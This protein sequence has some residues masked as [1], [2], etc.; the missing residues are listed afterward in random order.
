MKF[1]F[2]GP[3]ECKKI[4]YPGALKWIRAFINWGNVHECR[5][6]ITL[7]VFYSFIHLPL[8][9]LVQFPSNLQETFRKQAHGPIL[10]V[11]FPRAQEPV[12]HRLGA[13]KGAFSVQRPCPSLKDTGEVGDTGPHVDA[14]CV[15]P[16]ALCGTWAARCGGLAGPVPQWVWHWKL[17][18]MA[19]Q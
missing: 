4:N 17:G 19:R 13:F 1:F 5:A 11:Q 9:F 3:F 10:S 2:I 12:S 16:P 18:Q 15:V 14:V 8:L 6:T 7:V